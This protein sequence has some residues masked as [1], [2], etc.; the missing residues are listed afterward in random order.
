MIIVVS[1]NTVSQ[2]QT[3]RGSGTGVHG[4]ETV[5]CKRTNL[6]WPDLVWT[7]DPT[8]KTLPVRVIPQTLP[9][10]SGLG[11]GS[12]LGQTQP[13]PVPV[14]PRT[15]RVRLPV[16]GRRVGSGH[17]RLQAYIYIHVRGCVYVISFAYAEVTFRA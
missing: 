17:T 9:R 10:G 11:L 4:T 12:R 7:P 16:A 15:G 5:Y 6:A 3:V 8:R 14:C 1:S 13:V 2:Y